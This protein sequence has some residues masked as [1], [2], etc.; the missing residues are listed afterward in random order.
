MNGSQN[1]MLLPYRA[2]WFYVLGQGQ[3]VAG[4]ANSDSHSL[5]DNTV[6]LPRNIVYTDT[7]AGP[8]FDTAR[9]NASVKAGAS[10]GTNGPVIE[11]T[12]DTASGPKRFGLTPLVPSADAKLHLKVSAAPWVPVDEVRI[13]VNGTVVKTLSGAALSRP[14]N[15][16]GTEGLLRYQGSLPLSELVTR[17]GDA[18]LVVE[19]GRAL[20]LAKDLGGPAGTLDG[21][22]DTTD[23]NKDGVVDAR[24]VAE[25]SKYGPLMNPEL[26]ATE[27]DPQFHFSQ[28]VTGGYPMAFTNPFVLDRNGNG[29]FDAPG[30]VSP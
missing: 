13:V 6:G 12:L 22:P 28:V 14:T 27:A 8:G 15:P 25:G 5:T 3:L 19:A 24:D 30:V 2:F 4:T 10:F 18:W 21:I 11:A 29:R 20:P 17:A 7:V 9:F 26:P 1:D 23:N 16:L